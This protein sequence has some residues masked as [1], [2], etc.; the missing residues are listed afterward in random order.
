MLPSVETNQDLPITQFSLIID[1]SAFA[2]GLLANM[3][4]R[5]SWLGYRTTMGTYH[6]GEEKKFPFIE[7]QTSLAF[8]LFAENRLV[9]II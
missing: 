1:F 8:P 7:V 6:L 4:A 9:V 5:T 3:K 2:S